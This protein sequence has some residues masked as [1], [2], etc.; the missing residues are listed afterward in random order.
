MNGHV[1][2]CPVVLKL[3]LSAESPEELIKTKIPG[4]HPRDS[5]SVV[6]GVPRGLHV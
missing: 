1:C 5:A 4:P 3:G 2:S 6:L